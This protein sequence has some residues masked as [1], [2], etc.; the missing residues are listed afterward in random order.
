M[1]SISS[2]ISR[3]ENSKLRKSMQHKKLNFG[4]SAASNQGLSI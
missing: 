4:T 2:G 3:K 1:S